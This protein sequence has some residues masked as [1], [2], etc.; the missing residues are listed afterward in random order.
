MTQDVRISELPE[1]AT[2]DGTE[3]VPVV[4]SGQT[5]RTRVAALRRSPGIDDRAAATAVTI[6]AD[7]SVGL[8]VATPLH[9]LDVAGT[10]RIGHGPGD[11]R[12]YLGGTWAGGAA[13][14][15]F[16]LLG[17]TVWDGNRYLTNQGGAFGSNAVS[18]VS[19]DADGVALCHALSTG[20]TERSE[21][22]AVFGSYER[23]RATQTDVR[24]FVP[25][26]VCAG[27]NAAGAGGSIEFQVNQF[28]AFAPMADIKGVLGNA[29]GTETQGGLILRT[30]P[31]GAA[32]Q[33][34]VERLRVDQT[35]ATFANPVTVNGAV[36]PG[37]D[38]THDLGGPALRWDDIYATNA[39]IQTSDARSKT[40]VIDSPLGLAFILAL[41]PVRYRFKDVD[42]PAVTTRR[43]V[44]R[45]KTRQITRL[46]EAVR[47]VDGQLRLVMESET[48][49]EPVLRQEPL[50][51]ADGRPLVNADGTARLYTVAETERVEIE[52][53]Q[54]PARR[55]THRRPHFGL[56]AQ[57]VK[58]VLD[59]FGTDMGGYIHEPENDRHGLRYDEFIAPLIRAVQELAARI[60][61]L[62]QRTGG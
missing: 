13:G 49:A 40:D 45:E 17:S 57:E 20:N 42:E 11:A 15:R 8:G 18:A 36:V 61:A 37:A 19:A 14:W 39:A 26:R 21:T 28:A 4:Q 24:S 12:G 52:E 32:G 62:E 25:L 56:I 23:L 31:V 55:K 58:A 38:D 54:R 9:R 29:A 16:A 34:L 33:P 2:L 6:A 3:S 5:R 7:G 41:R 53:E 47:R 27:G 44:E 10:L 1:A 48:V 60:H 51:D 43:M 50:F 59:R 35:G 46:R 30:R 22:A